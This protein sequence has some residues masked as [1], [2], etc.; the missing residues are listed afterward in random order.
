MPGSVHQPRT[1]AHLIRGS[2]GV[3]RHRNL[4]LL[5]KQAQV[6][7]T[8]TGS[9]DRDLGHSA[10]PPLNDHP[11]AAPTQHCRP[12]VAK[13]NPGALAD[14]CVFHEFRDPKSRDPC[15]RFDGVL[16]ARGSEEAG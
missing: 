3:Q 5:Q 11:P 8:H 2:V 15:E 13:L 7:P 1:G 16:D 14:H 9:N 10:L 6:Q 4:A 12:A